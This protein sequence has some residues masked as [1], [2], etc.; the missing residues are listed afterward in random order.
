[1][2]TVMTRENWLAYLDQ[3]FYIALRCNG[4]ITAEGRRL[5]L[6]RVTIH[7][8]LFISFFIHFFTFHVYGCFAYVPWVCLAPCVFS[9]SR[10]RERVSGAVGLVTVT[11]YR[12]VV[13]YHMCAGNRTRFLLKSG[14][15]WT[16]ELCLQLW[17]SVVQANL[18]LVTFPLLLPHY[19]L[20]VCTATAGWFGSHFFFFQGAMFW[21]EELR[22]V[23]SVF[24]LIKIWAYVTCCQGVI[25]F[26]CL[27]LRDN[28]ERYKRPWRWA[29]KRLSIDTFSLRDASNTL[30]L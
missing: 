6:S 30:L 28:W 26:F 9:A 15:C 16:L 20:P 17:K 4:C 10:C 2:K 27:A 24:H 14:Q 21:K 25:P 8:G 19:S 1:M 7:I 12:W 22:L 5:R 29:N 13:S 18:E 3:Y 11:C 23:W